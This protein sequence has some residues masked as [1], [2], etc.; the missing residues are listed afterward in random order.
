MLSQAVIMLI[1]VLALE[2]FSR[3]VVQERSAFGESFLRLRAKR[4]FVEIE[5]NDLV[6]PGPQF[7][8]VLFV[9]LHLGIG[10][11]SFG[12]LFGDLGFEVR[13]A[14]DELLI[15]FVPLCGEAGYYLLLLRTVETY[16]FKEH[17]IAFHRGDLVLQDLQ[18]PHIGIDLR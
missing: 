11:L 12:A 13:A 7:Y 16:G 9:L 2:Y 1:V 6:E 15:R 8:E 10:E 18:T 14:A 3:I 5:S 4:R 17:R